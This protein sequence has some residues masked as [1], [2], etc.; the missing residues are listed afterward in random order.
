MVVKIEFVILGILFF[1]LCGL[2]AW[3]M[4]ISFGLPQQACKIIVK[5]V[6]ALSVIWTLYIT[7]SE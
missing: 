3:G 6:I 7:F 5:V 4:T 1:V 2:I